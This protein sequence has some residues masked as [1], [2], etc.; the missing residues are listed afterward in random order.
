MELWVAMTGAGEDVAG[1]SLAWSYLRMTCLGF[2]I[3]LCGVVGLPS[4]PLLTIF[5]KTGPVMN[6]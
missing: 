5:I 2:V 6:H 1:E 4:S 3:P